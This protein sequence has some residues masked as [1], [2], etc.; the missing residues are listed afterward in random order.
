MKNAQNCV[1]ILSMKLYGFQKL[2][3]LDYVGKLACTVFTGGCNFRCPFCHNA[4]LV[5][6]PED[7][8]NEEEVF[9]YLYKRKGLLEGICVS[10]G[11]PLLSD[12]I[13]PFLETCKRLGYAVKLDTNGAFPQ[14]LI[15]AVE[16]GLVDRVAMDVKNCK[17]KY[18]QT[19]GIPNLSLSKVEESVQ[20]LLSGRVDYELRTTVV[21]EFHGEEDF[22][23]I[24]KWIAGA[25]EYYLQG[26]VD[27]GD[28]IGGNMHAV[29]KEEMER[30][31]AAVVPYVPNARLRGV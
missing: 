8:V 22:V 1:T 29:C 19:T 31:R 12:G 15:R 24:G 17:E 5:L 4:S 6:R 23:R 3:T 26:F 28:L 10:G 18:A 21:A 13:F 20:F 30:F 7:E 27:S 9:S 16:E 2:T 25:K 11:E 14:R